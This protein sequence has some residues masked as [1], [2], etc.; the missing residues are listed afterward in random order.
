M[1]RS[2]LSWLM[3]VKN[4]KW[5]CLCK[6]FWKGF[7]EVGWNWLK[8]VE[9]GK[10]W[11]VLL[12]LVEIGRSWLSGFINGNIG[13]YSGDGNGSGLGPTHIVQVPFKFFGAWTCS[14]AYPLD[15]AGPAGPRWICLVLL[16]CFFWA[17][18][19]CIFL[20]HHRNWTSETACPHEGD[21][22]YSSCQLQLLSERKGEERDVKGQ[23][24]PLLK[25]AERRKRMKDQDIWQWKK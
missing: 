4:A 12:E 10:N 16:P 21:H 20:Q 9:V 14:R 3:L 22:L 7:V 25:A 5:R 11:I 13:P 24:S 23:G 19:F 2:W 17:P 18:R 8:L 15:R 6:K 1:G